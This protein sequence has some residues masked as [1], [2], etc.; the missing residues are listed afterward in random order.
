MELTPAA[1]LV[2]LTGAVAPTPPSVTE[3]CPGLS[4]C[5]VFAR[6]VDSDPTALDVA[7]DRL[8]TLLLVELRPVDS[9]VTPLCAVLMP[10]DADVDSEVTEL[11]VELSPVDSELMPV[12]VDV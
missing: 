2:S 5:T 10:V 3:V 6:P 4:Y 12:E 9:D 1:T 8:L 11:L 7:V